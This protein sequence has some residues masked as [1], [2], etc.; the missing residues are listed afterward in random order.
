MW[1]VSFCIYVFFCWTVLFLLRYLTNAFGQFRDRKKYRSSPQLSANR[2]FSSSTSSANLFALDGN[3]TSRRSNKTPKS[4][5]SSPEPFSYSENEKRIITESGLVI[6]QSFGSI[7]ARTDFFN[8]F[9]EDVA[10]LAPRFWQKWFAFGVYFSLFAM[11]ASLAV[12]FIAAYKWIGRETHLR[13]LFFDA[14][15]DASDTLA[16]ASDKRIGAGGGLLLDANTQ[17]LSDWL[18]PVIPGIN[19]PVGHIPYYFLALVV[20]S[21]FHEMGHAIAAAS[22]FFLSI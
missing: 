11:T 22:Y 6:E 16:L 3:E 2:D 15:P 7:R 13:A 19:L 21:V 18:I 5:R 14:V 17:A 10:S 4:V 9:F 1:I 12:V 8:L 20:S